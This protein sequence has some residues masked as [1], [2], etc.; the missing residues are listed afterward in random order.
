MRSIYPVNNACMVFQ[1]IVFGIALIGDSPVR[2]TAMVWTDD[3]SGH[4]RNLEDALLLNDTA[5]CYSTEEDDSPNR[6]V[7]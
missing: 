5:K 3:P 6:Y 7:K 2:G 1:L 4:H